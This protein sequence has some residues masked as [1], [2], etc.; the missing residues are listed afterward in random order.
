MRNCS[1]L[2]LQHTSIVQY[3]ICKELLFNIYLLAFNH[4]QRK[5]STPE[6]THTDQFAFSKDLISNTDHSAFA[7]AYL[8]IP[9]M[10]PI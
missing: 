10:I 6:T 1:S 5:P 3:C 7:G 2:Q 9:L 4:G 8:F